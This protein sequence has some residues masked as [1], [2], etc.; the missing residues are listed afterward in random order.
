MG[1]FDLF[2]NKTDTGLEKALTEF[3]LAMFP[4]G[5]PD[6]FSDKMEIMLL[7]SDGTETLTCP[8]IAE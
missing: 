7:V 4:N 1:L 2:S 5:E 6:L 3:S 8:F